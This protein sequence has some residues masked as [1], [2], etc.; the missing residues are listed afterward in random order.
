METRS[1]S[2][3]LSSFH[4]FSVERVFPIRFDD[5]WWFQSLLLTRWESSVHN[6]PGNHITNRIEQNARRREWV[7]I[8]LGGIWFGRLVWQEDKTQNL[9]FSDP[10][11][12]FLSISLLINYFSICS[13]QSFVTHE[14]MPGNQKL[15]LS[16][17]VKWNWVSVGI[18]GRSYQ[19]RSDC[20]IK[21]Q[22]EFA[23]CRFWSFRWNFLTKVAQSKL[24]L[25]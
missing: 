2:R 9:T 20:F 19:I 10:F 15:L 25:R 14:M 11:L 1:L 21:S 12:C 24:K 5:K 13:R 7:G 18:Q 4:C 16:L 6:S 17:S 3:A 22:S 23:I 8:Q